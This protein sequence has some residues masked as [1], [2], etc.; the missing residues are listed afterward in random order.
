MTNFSIKDFMS[1]INH[2]NLV[3]KNISLFDEHK[4]KSQEIYRNL[5]FLGY[6]IIFII[7]DNYGIMADYLCDRYIF[8]C[9]VF[10]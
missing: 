6:S 3:R 2:E 5:S 8:G 1:N 9:F 4:F 10:V 7:T